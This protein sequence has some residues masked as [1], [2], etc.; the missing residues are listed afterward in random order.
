[1]PTVVCNGVTVNYNDVGIGDPVVLIHCSSSSHR[2]WRSLWELLQNKYRVIAIDM[3]DWGGTGSWTKSGTNLLVDET[4]LINEVIA[5]I[6]E[7]IYLVGH[8]YGGTIAYHLAMESPRKIKSLTLIEPMLGWLLDPQKESKYYA[9]LRGVAEYFWG[10]YSLG[11]AE[12]GIK[13]YFDYWN[14]NGAWE[15]L[16]PGLADYVLAGAGKNFN[17]FEAIFK[18]GKGLLQPECFE[19]PVL[20]IGGAESRQPPLRMLELLEI[21][22]PDSRRHLIEG[23]SHMSPITHS[24][25]VNLIIRDFI[26]T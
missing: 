22:F 14:G 12:E 19:Q 18:G 7:R 10:K 4:N 21:L 1:V 2:Q 5:G 6:G 24:K 17:E 26:S 8:S 20:L 13:H 25:Q 9:E 3:L 15:N 23:A 16:D 11:E